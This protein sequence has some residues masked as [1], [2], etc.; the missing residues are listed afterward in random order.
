MIWPPIYT[1]DNRGVGVGGGSSEGQVPIMCRNVQVRESAE[2]AP[3][4]LPF[5]LKGLHVRVI[6]WDNFSKQIRRARTH[7][8]H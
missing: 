6:T 1:S 2:M 4:S 5:L 7:T 3:F 8:S